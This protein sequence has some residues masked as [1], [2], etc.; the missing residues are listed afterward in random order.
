MKKLSSSDDG[1]FRD[2]LSNCKLRRSV[3]NSSDKEEE[4]R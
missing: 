1:S 2:M 4:W 3:R